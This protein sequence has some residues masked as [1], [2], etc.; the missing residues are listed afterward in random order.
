MTNQHCHQ[1]CGKCHKCRKHKH[2]KSCK[3]CRVITKR[4]FLDKETCKVSKTFVI[5]KPGKYCLGESIIF[6]PIEPGQ[7]AIEILSDDVKLD[8]CCNKLEQVVNVLSLDPL[9]TGESGTSIVN[10]YQQ[11][12]GFSTGDNVTIS[13][14]D[15]FD[16]IY[17]GDINGSHLIVKV[18]D[19]NYTIDVSPS[20]AGIGFKTGG[21]GNITINAM[22][23]IVGIRIGQKFSETA[24]FKRITITNGTILKFTGQGIG[25]LNAAIFFNPPSAFEDLTFTDLNVLECGSSP[26]FFFASG[27]D[28]DS[29]ASQ[30]L[31]FPEV[32]VAYK[33]IIIKRCNVNKCLGNGAIDVFT[34]EN[35]VIEDIQANDLLNTEVIFGTFAHAYFGRNLQMFNCQGNGATETDPLALFSQAGGAIISD[36]QNVHLK[37]CQFNDTFGESCRIVN[38]NVSDTVNGVFENCQFNNSRGGALVRLISGIHHSDRQFQTDRTDAL[39]FINCQFNG[40]DHVVPGQGN[41]HFTVG[42]AGITTRNL[43]FDNCE[44]MRISAPGIDLCLGWFIETSLADVLS[45]VGSAMN[46]TF[47]DCVT[48]DIVAHDGGAVGYLVNLLNLSI[49][50]QQGELNNVTFDNCIS[51]NISGNTSSKE[52]AG[53]YFG[54]PAPVFESLFGRSTNLFIKN[55]RISDIFSNQENPSPI[56]AGIVANGVLHSVICN[57]SVTDCDRGILLTGRAEITPDKPFQLAATLADA[58]AFPPVIIDLTGPLPPALPLQTFENTTQ[59]NQVD[60]DPQMNVDTQRNLLISPVNLNPLGWNV[61]DAILYDSNGGGNILNLVDGTTYYVVVSKPGFSE[62]G[63]IQDNKVDNCLI[64]GY[65]DDKEPTSSIWVNNNAYNNGATPSHT[66]NYDINWSGVVPVLTGDL[67]NYPTGSEKAYNMSFIP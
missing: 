42:Y 55:C 41:V 39:K 1:K 66:E 67:A 46:I 20:T 61:G 8:L 64:S 54:V 11:N 24:V 30:D 12:H 21:G 4:D 9:T 33:N 10:V 7:S 63:V 19:D 60:I 58:L 2:K 57:N 25:A 53:I 36:C 26:S 44:A 14:A 34:F 17:A 18:D 13:N 37:N 43:I 40:S 3:D 16:G 27:I 5:D 52:V 45:E 32:P 31:A 28:L 48:S 56:S 29:F 22:P 51:T 15:T 62:N 23:D 47:R 49:V 6:D 65:Q 35:L 59:G 38:T 50:G